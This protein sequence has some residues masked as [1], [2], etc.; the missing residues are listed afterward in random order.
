MTPGHC[1]WRGQ[2]AALARFHTRGVFGVSAGVC[3]G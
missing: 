2:R 1:R 3:D